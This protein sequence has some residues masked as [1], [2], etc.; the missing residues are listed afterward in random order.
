MCYKLSM[1]NQSLTAPQLA[2][3]A[4]A[5]K[6]NGLCSVGLGYQTTQVCARSLV[7]LGLF[8]FV[9][10]TAWEHGVGNRKQY[11]LTPHGRVVVLAGRMV[12]QL[13][14]ADDANDRTCARNT[15]RTLTR[16]QRSITP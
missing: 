4:Y 1:A 7:R 16:K 11:R 2:A 3:L 10:A 8:E 15:L 6:R 14:T 5:A 13:T 12:Y 9:G